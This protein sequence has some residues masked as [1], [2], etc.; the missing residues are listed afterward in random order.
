MYDTPTPQPLVSIV[1][2]AYNS[3]DYILETIDS[4]TIQTYNNI[5]VIVVNDGSTDQT[6]SIVSSITD[7]RVK[8]ITIENSGGPSKPRNVGVKASRGDYVAIFDS[9]DVMHPEKIKTSINAFIKC[10]EASFLFTNF[11]TIDGD[12]NI[13]KESFLD[14]YKTLYDLEHKVISASERMITGKC[15]ING[16]ADA[17]FIGTSSVIAKRDVFEDVGDFDENVKNGDDYNMWARISL[18]Y[19]SVFIDQPLHMYRVHDKSISKS[20]QFNRLENL[21]YLHIKHASAD[22]PDYFR[23]KNFIRV[24]KYSYTLAKLSI[25]MGDRPLARK[26]ARLAVEYKY[27]PFKSYFLFWLSFCPKLITK[28]FIQL[29]QKI[30]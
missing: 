17:N 7:K 22:F 27:K 2:P 21:V 13:I 24:G 4:I 8:I 30:T 26:Y 14:N 20:N 1:I 11:Q 23:R 29:F 28:I 5:E 10:P 16:L 25:K 12:G 6:K 3:G 9:D 15:L 19:H 18:K